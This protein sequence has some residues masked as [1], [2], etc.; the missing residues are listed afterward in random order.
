MSRNVTLELTALGAIVVV[1][2]S[3][4]TPLYPASQKKPASKSPTT[5][6]HVMKLPP[7][8]QAKVE[9]AIVKML[10][11]LALNY[12]QDS[13]SAKTSEDVKTDLASD[14]F[15]R[16]HQLLLPYRSR[17]SSIAT[18]LGI[19]GESITYFL[20]GE[21]GTFPF[22]VVDYKGSKCFVA[23]IATSDV[24]NTLRLSSAKLRAAKVASSHA[25]PALRAL[26][27]EL[28]GTDITTV[29]VFVTFGTKDFLDE[30][31]LATQPESVAVLSR[32]SDARAF[33]QGDMSDTEFIRK[34][35]VLISDRNAS[36]LDYTKTE[37]HLE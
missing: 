10:W 20:Y 27:S 14:D 5:K 18:R 34:A 7:F 9:G 22:D 8:E 33:E 28:S 17:L 6:S 12:K 4:G 19:F 37:L 23:I 13:S 35:T 15:F 32:L 30:S 36:S 16:E 26:A 3:M 21:K 25:L 31:A 11:S 2:T 24:Y 29:A 1:V